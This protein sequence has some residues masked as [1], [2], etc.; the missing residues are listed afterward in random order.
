MRANAK[1]MN[2]AT[3]GVTQE[4]KPD[5]PGTY[6]NKRHTDSITKIPE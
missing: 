5:K 2:K 6:P 3:G 4:E 1:P